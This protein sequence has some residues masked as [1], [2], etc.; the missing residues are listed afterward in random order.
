MN[1]NPLFRIASIFNILVGGGL[2][3]AY[4]WL[5]PILG[6]DGP[7]TVWFHITVGIVLIFGYAYGCI[8]L[9]PRRY[10]PYVLL[11]AIGKLTFAVVIYAHWLRGTAPAALAM[12]VTA[13]VVFA[14]LF[15]AYLRSNPAAPA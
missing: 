6:I 9:N 13:D 2:L 14:A 5:A 11:G 1:A 12:I 7:P 8:S 3:L 4:P 15:V 10:R